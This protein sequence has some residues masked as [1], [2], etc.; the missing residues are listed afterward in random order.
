MKINKYVVWRKVWHR[1]PPLN[2]NPISNKSGRKM[3]IGKDKLVKSIRDL[4]HMCDWCKPFPG[5]FVHMLW[6]C[7]KWS[8]FW[9]LV[10]ETLL[11]FLMNWAFPLIGIT[12]TFV[13]LMQQ[14]LAYCWNAYLIY[15]EGLFTSSMC[16]MYIL[17]RSS[18][19]WNYLQR[20]LQTRGNHFTLLC[21][22][23]HLMH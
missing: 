10:F 14:F 9:D 4:D 21:K 11:D 15:V 17:R 6:K 2:W 7:S 8:S 16:I 20:A 18:A 1:K 3:F 13:K 22:I 12:W 23:L 19:L 5:T